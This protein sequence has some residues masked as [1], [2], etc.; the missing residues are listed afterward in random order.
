MN[1]T[2]DKKITSLRGTKQSLPYRK[3]A[4]F[5]I[6]L[7]ISLLIIAP[8][9]LYIFWPKT[10]ENQSTQISTETPI[11]TPVEVPKVIESPVVTTLPTSYDISVPYAAQAPFSNW[12]VHEESCEEAA[13]YMY[14]AYFDD[15]MYTNNKIPE[16]ELDTVFHAMKQW[17]VTN[18]NSEPDLTMTA[19]GDFARNY[20]GY[21]P[22]VKQGITAEDIKKA[23]SSDHPVLVPVMTHSLQNS[24]YGP[25]TTYHVLFIKGYDTTGVITNDAGVGNGPNKHYTWEILWQAIDAQKAEMKVGREML[26]LTK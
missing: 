2:K 4:K 14:K 8:I 16:T 18:Y 12:D 1:K 19:L 17:Q 7:G 6:I 10:E 24:M 20:Y 26:Y 9:L 23:I 5:L 13:L 11:E 15:T 3:K 22:T 21:T 25:Q